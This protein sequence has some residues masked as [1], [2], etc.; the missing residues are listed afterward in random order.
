MVL[1]FLFLAWRGRRSSWQWILH[2]IAQFAGVSLSLIAAICLYLAITSGLVDTPD[3]GI[4]GG[5]SAAHVLGWY[6]DRT[7]GALPG[8]SV[9]SLPMYVWRLVWLAW[10]LW[11]AWR[12]IHWGGWGWKNFSPGGVFRKWEKTTP[13]PGSKGGESKFKPTSGAPTAE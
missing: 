6:V 13:S 10:A 2:F 9:V 8:A 1:W 11:L 4:G 5:G 7:P 3:F 12:L